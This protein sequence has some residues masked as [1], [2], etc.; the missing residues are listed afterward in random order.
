MKLISSKLLPKGR[1][2][3]SIAGGNFE[4]LTFELR[5]EGGYWPLVRY[6]ERIETA[7]SPM[8]IQTATLNADRS[9][10]GR[11]ELR[12]TVVNLYPTQA[13][14]DAGEEQT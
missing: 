10:E 13:G 1:E 2:A 11:G 9:Q 6:V 8:W 7:P 5:L 4:P 12:L 14:S 3:A